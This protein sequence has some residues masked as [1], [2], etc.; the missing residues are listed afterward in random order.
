M[1]IQEV[2][3]QFDI[4]KKAINLYEEKG[5]VKPQKDNM[6]YR[7]YSHYDIQKL[8]Q[9]KQLRN[10]GFSIQEIKDILIHQHYE[11]FDKKI[12]EYQKKYYELDTSLQYISDVKDKII[13]QQDIQKLSH[14]MDQTYDLKN[15]TSD[16]NV[17]YPFD[18]YTFCL[19]TVAISILLSKRQDDIY[20][21]IVLIIWCIAGALSLANIQTY[22][23]KIIK[24]FKK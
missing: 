15:I 1:Y 10:L 24:K 22:I 5:L 7:D 6:G 3:Q 4:S 9:I 16:D 14:E 2:S 8:L 21:F 17:T 11:I 23:Y 12:Q 20:T 13:N 19:L 18:V